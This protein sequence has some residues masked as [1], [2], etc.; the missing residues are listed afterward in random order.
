MPCK[1]CGARKTVKSHILPRSLMHSIRGD[2]TAMFAA[3]RGRGRWVEYQSG[4]WDKSILCQ[5]CEAS[6]GDCD[7]YAVRWIRG[8]SQKAVSLP[9]GLGFEVP[10]PKPALLVKFVAATLWRAAVSPHMSHEGLSL[11]PWEF[12]LRNFVFNDVGDEPRVIVV[13]KVWTVDGKEHPEIAVPPYGAP[14]WGK[15]AYTFDLSGFGWG[16][17]LDNRSYPQSPFHNDLL[18]NQRDP[19]PVLNAGTKDIPEDDEL[20]DIVVA[21]FTGSATRRRP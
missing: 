8:F 1:V 9:S 19:M 20:L 15:R 17:R 14:K 3:D 18:C 5:D 16:I 7:D 13:R 6:L 12:S 10:N 2:E 4:P 11:G 21:A